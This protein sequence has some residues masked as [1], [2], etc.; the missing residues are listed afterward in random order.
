VAYHVHGTPAGQ[1]EADLALQVPGRHN[2]QNALAA[3]AVGLEI[4]VPVDRIVTALGEFRGAERRDQQRGTARGVTVIDDYGHHPTEIAAVLQAARD[5]APARIVAVVQPH[6]YSR[7]RDCLG[8]F[9]PSLAA[10][11]VVILTDIYSAGEAPIAGASLDA[12]A[13]AIRPHVPTLDVVPALDDLA[14]AVA[15]Q[16]RPGDLVITLGAG[17]I[18]SVGERILDALREMGGAA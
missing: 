14:P 17:S 13:E 5:G 2:V 3:F 18:A 10:A 12:L 4:G 16:S 9:G 1:G 6:R 8:Q 11:D 7:T 15:R